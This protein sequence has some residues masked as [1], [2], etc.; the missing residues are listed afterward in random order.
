MWRKFDRGSAIKYVRSEGRRIVQLNAY[1]LALGGGE[2]QMYEYLGYEFFS[3]I[4]Y[5]IKIK[6]KEPFM[7]PKLSIHI[8]PVQLKVQPRP[9]GSWCFKLTFSNGFVQ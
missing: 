7:Q 9:Q 6:E 2:F 1:W 8:S 3:Q 5:K 4:R